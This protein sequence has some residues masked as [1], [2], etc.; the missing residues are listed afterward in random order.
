MV[1]FWYVVGSNTEAVRYKLL[2]KTPKGIFSIGGLYVLTCFTLPLAIQ[3]MFFLTNTT[4]SASIVS[5]LRVALLPDIPD[6]TY[7]AAFTACWTMAE[8]TA[9]LVC[10]C[11]MTLGP[12]LKRVRPG[13]GFSNKSSDPA[14]ARTKSHTRHSSRMNPGGV[15]PRSRSSRLGHSA[16]IGGT[17]ET[18]LCRDADDDDNN[19]GGPPTTVGARSDAAGRPGADSADGGQAFE[20][21][22]VSSRPRT[23]HRRDS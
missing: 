12:I 1:G 16:W 15:A 10:P 2:T 5:I 18:E 22:P 11:L 3:S 17:S 9:G 6:V 7:T 21:G 14:R 20:L 19:S 8:T 4:S 23:G 13:L